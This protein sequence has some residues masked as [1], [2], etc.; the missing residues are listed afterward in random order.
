MNGETS[1]RMRCPTCGRSAVSH[2]IC[3]A[4][5]AGLV[6]AE[7]QQ[8]MEY[9]ATSLVPTRPFELSPTTR[10]RQSLATSVAESGGVLHDPWLGLGSSETSGRVIIAR[11]APHEPMDFDP[12]RWVA[13]PAWGL[14]LLVSPVAISVIVWW[15]YGLVPALGVGFVLLLILRYLFSD[16]LLQTWH[17]TAALNGRHIV[18]PMP[19]LM[20]R[21]RQRDGREIQL[22]VKGQLD[23]GTLL[24]G[25][26]IR[27][28]GRWRAGVFRVR[29]AFCE[30][31]GAMITPR[32]PNAFMLAVT[33]SVLLLLTSLW[34]WLAAYPWAMARFDEARSSW[35]HQFTLPT[36]IEITP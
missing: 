34:L 2:G 4:C 21:L 15:A 36:N 1:T 3:S 33:G 6:S 13:I 27:A 29:S 22:R 30:R 16:R 24:E 8:I 28:T 7:Q 17:L 18:E 31:T 20:L 23:G 25:D 32:Q 5:G 35:S 12:W 10:T 19:V 9:G 26:R 14:L 11:Q